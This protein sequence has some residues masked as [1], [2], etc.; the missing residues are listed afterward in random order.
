MALDDKGWEQ[1]SSAVSLGG[2]GLR[3]PST[4]A[5]SFFLSTC[6]SVSPLADRL[7]GGANDVDVASA[8]AK[9]SAQTAG[10]TPPSDISANKASTWQNAVDKASSDDMALRI[11]ARGVCGAVRLRLYRQIAAAIQLGNAACISE[12][13][14]PPLT[15][16]RFCREHFLCST[17]KLKLIIST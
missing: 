10:A 15:M 11:R 1:A 7:C 14:S 5:P 4:L 8:L 6:A 3:V 9:W 16:R 12:A 17:I 13:H 2:L